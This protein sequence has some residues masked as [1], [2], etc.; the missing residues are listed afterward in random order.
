MYHK[1]FF[2]LNMIHEPMLTTK[3]SMSAI[4]NPH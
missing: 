4:G 3:D 1:R 2:C